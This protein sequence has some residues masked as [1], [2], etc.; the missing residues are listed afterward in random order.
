MRRNITITLTP[1]QAREIATALS[2][3]AADPSFFGVRSS[4]I[5]RAR[6]RLLDAM[7]GSL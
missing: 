7:A 4:L 3:I 6:R 2:Y 1:A 5:N